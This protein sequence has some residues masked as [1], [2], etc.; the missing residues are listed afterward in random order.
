MPSSEAGTTE[1]DA[2]LAALDHP[3][4][5]AVVAFRAEFL[6]AA[7]S[8][9]ER[10]AWNAPSFARDGVDRVTF[11]LHPRQVCQL[12]LHCG[13]RPREQ[14]PPVVADPLG[15]LVMRTSD[16]G[17]IGFATPADL[18]A[19]QHDVVALVAAWTAG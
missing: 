12:V 1:V 14:A 4:R 10:I 19:R 6:A 17:V 11:R 18:T 2:W 7:P 16:R 8:L 5:D 9:T 15:L 13:V 3:F